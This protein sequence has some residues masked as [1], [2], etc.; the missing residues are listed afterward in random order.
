MKKS[1]LS[2]AILAVALISPVFAA[3]QTW[4]GKISDS[5]CGAKHKAPAE[6]EA[7]MSDADCTA[8]CIKAGAKYVFVNDAKIYNISNQDFADLPM[9]A[10]HTVKLTGEMTGTSVRVTKIEMPKDK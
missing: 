8:A 2:G 5:D 7:A 4:V 6:H 3:E 9:H 10:G 1:L